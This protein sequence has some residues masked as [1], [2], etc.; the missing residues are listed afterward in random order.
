[1]TIA[2]GENLGIVFQ[3]D[4][5]YV[6]K[7]TNRTNLGCDYYDVTLNGNYCTTYHKDELDKIIKGERPLEYIENKKISVYRKD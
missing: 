6:I 7:T 3:N 2:K 1:M 4:E 5:L